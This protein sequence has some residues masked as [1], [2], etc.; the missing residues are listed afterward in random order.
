MGKIEYANPF[1]PV[2]GHTPP[3]FA[4][5]KDEI[6]QF[7]QLLGQKAVVENLVL[8]GLKGVGKTVLLSE[9]KPIAMKNRWLWVGADLSEKASLTETNIAIR[10]MVDLA[11]VTS[12]VPFDT[13]DAKQIRFREP[14][15]VTRN[16]DYWTLEEIYNGTPGLVS[17]RLK[18]VLEIACSAIQ[19][20]GFR[21][22]VFAYDEAQNM[23]DHAAQE[24]YPLSLMLDVVH[25]LQS[26]GVAMMLVLCGLP[27]LFPKLVEARTY[28]ER[29]FRV[30]FLNALSVEEARDAI[31]IP[32][33]KWLT[34]KGEDSLTA[35]IFES[36]G[37]PYFIQFMCR[38]VYDALWNHLAEPASVV[39]EDIIRKLDTVFFSGRW[40]RTTDRQ[41]ELLKAI[42]SLE[43]CDSEFTI[44]ETLVASKMMPFKSFG[45]SQVNQMLAKLSDIGLVYKNRHGRYA[46]AV[47]LF[48]KFIRR[49]SARELSR[50][51]TAS[52]ARERRGKIS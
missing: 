2:A 5:R 1:C 28:S 33:E 17:D 42:S 39:M 14:K 41:R 46:F 4:G 52:V 10:M 16:L 40:E 43:N 45:A 3:Y 11:A 9:L 21:G 35:A 13:S 34:Q 38:E 7:T 12:H 30:M 44:Q 48:G 26:K 29:M 37:Y 36:K 6:E 50:S 25:S 31:L 19:K 8:T 15:K 18:P 32:L 23:T 47:P 22:V 24:E 51:A 20:S 49:Q 27:T